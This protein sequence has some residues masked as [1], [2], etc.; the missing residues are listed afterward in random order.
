[1]PDYTDRPEYTVKLGET[2]YTIAFSVAPGSSLP[3]GLILVQSSNR[4]AHLEGTPIVAGVYSF[5]LR[6]AV[7]NAPV[8]Y[9]ET[10][11]R[12]VFLKLRKKL[13]E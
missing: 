9:A 6:A 1:L 7:L 12:P 8:D 10:T 2:F 3:P 5:T 4:T 11:E 13:G